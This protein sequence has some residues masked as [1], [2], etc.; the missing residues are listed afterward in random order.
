[1]VPLSIID[2]VSFPVTMGYVPTALAVLAFVVREQCASPRSPTAPAPSSAGTCA[3][4]SDDQGRPLFATIRG[5]LVERRIDQGGGYLIVVKPNE[6]AANQAVVVTREVYDAVG[7][8]E[9]ARVITLF[10]YVSSAVS[11]ASPPFSCVER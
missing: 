6:A 8:V 3:R 7:A 4:P 1:V 10:A 9:R 2:Q 11:G 5:E